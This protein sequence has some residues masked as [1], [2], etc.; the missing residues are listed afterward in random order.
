[1]QATSNTGAH[2]CLTCGETCKTAKGLESH[3]NRFPDCEPE[4]WERWSCDEVHSLQ[5]PGDPSQDHSE[6]QTGPVQDHTE[7]DR[8]VSEP[9]GHVVS[10]MIEP[11]IHDCDEDRYN[12]S[13][14][15]W[16]DFIYKARLTISQQNML[17]TV[18]N[19][20]AMAPEYCLMRS[21]TDFARVGREMIVLSGVGTGCS[22]EVGPNKDHTILFVDPLIA[23]THLVSDK[24]NGAGFTWTPAAKYSDDGIRV[25][26]TPSSADWWLRAQV[27]IC[28]A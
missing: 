14:V 11:A 10:R 21:A 6:L 5:R 9:A 20:K 17:F 4:H 19:N 24:R 16:W 2:R 22:A 13:T 26:D 23:I 3:F 15:G 8:E 12:I 27:R 1:M 25:Y 18:L 28:E 7:T